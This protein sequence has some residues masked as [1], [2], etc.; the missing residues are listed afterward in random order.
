MRKLYL[1]T[2][3]CW[4]SLAVFAAIGDKIYPTD[5]MIYQVTSD[6]EVQVVGYTNAFATTDLVIPPSVESGGTNYAV[7]AISVFI[8]NTTIQTLRVPGTVKALAT[9]WQGFKGC[10]N[11]RSVIFEKGFTKLAKGAFNGC[12]A[13]KRVTLP[14]GVTEIPVYTFQNSGLET[15]TFPSTVATINGNAFAG[16]AGLSEIR[17]DGKM[18]PTFINN[19][20][21]KKFDTVT[22]VVPT[23]TSAAFA[24]ATTANP[25]KE[26]RED[27]TLGMGDQTS[28]WDPL[29]DIRKEDFWVYIVFGQSNAEGYEALPTAEDK[30][31]NPNLYN[32]RA[33]D[34]NDAEDG[35]GNITTPW[36]EWENV[37]EPNCRKT[38]YHPTKM[39]WV[40]AFGE[41]MLRL[42]PGKKFA[43]VHV[44]VASAAIK[45]FD[46]AQYV[47]YL[48]DANTSKWVKYK[49]AGAYGGNPYQRI[50][51]AAK[52]AQQFGTVKG[53]LMHQGEED[54]GQAY[55]PGTV[56]KVYQD[57][58]TDLSLQ[59]SEVPLIMGEPTAYV[60]NIANQVAVTTPGNDAYIPNSYLVEA[61][62]LPYNTLH[63]TH[64]G[65][66]SLGKRYAQV[67]SGDYTATSVEEIRNGLTTGTNG[68]DVKLSRHGSAILALEASQP[69]VEVSLL[70]ADGRLLK[71]I[72]RRPFMTLKINI[73]RW[74]ENPLLVR[75]KAANGA[76]TVIKV[77]GRH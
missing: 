73:E 46:K 5:N 64:D 61:S 75:C 45:L 44:A 33:Y 63:F 27:A 52:K 39:G 65:Y 23:G 48:A 18:P 43:F 12:K 1:I 35:L 51:D 36:G 60:G 54:G 31:P 67:A 72:A 49:A 53:I 32:L 70:A 59:G 58:L 28:E 25:F 4:I 24:A 15:I 22:L 56:K 20:D 30:I 19:S 40:K 47:A 7:T 16:C 50:I 13:L 6:T 71:Q 8:N 21:S 77:A 17:F 42:H 14:E 2:V 3:L 76:R 9:N 66:V 11:L 10:T 55:W 26:I 68:L 62:D 69:L 37:S 38:K 34:D 57:M 29:K 74:K 41:E